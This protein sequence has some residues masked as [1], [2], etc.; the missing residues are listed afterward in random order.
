MM[1]VTTLSKFII[2]IVGAQELKSLGFG[3]RTNTY[4]AYL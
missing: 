3:S 2:D 4:C 1:Q